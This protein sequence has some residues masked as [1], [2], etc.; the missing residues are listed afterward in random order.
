MCLLKPFCNLRIHINGRIYEGRCNYIYLCSV[1]RE[2]KIVC[3]MWL[4][5]CW[6]RRRPWNTRVNVKLS[7]CYPWLQQ[8]WCPP[9]TSSEHPLTDSSPWCSN[10]NHPINTHS[11][12]GSLHLLMEIMSKHCLKWWLLTGRKIAWVPEGCLGWGESCQKALLVLLNVSL[13]ITY[14]GG[15]SWCY[16]ANFP[17]RWIFLLIVWKR[18]KIN[19]I[20]S[21]Y[22]NRSVKGWWVKMSP[23]SHETKSVN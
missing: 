6:K 11:T 20:S 5:S 19:L 7:W 15:T 1:L 22:I 10:D 13:V 3:G 12:S 2:K 23:S 16:E 8:L 4:G 18:L 21:D 9:G 14:P 17:W